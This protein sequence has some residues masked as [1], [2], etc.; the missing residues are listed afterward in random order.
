MGPSKGWRRVCLG[1]LV[2]VKH[3]FAFSGECFVEGRTPDV[4]V[5]PG[6]FALGGGFK[7][8]KPKYYGGPVP[9]PEFILSPGD[10][11]V[12][13]TDLSKTSD[14]LGYGAVVP[15]LSGVRLLHNQ[16]IGRVVVNRPDLTSCDYLHWV[17][18]SD[19]YR[20]EVL[21]SASGSTVKHTAPSRIEAYRFLLPPLE[22]QRA[23]AN[24]LGTLDE[25]IE[26]N[27][28]TNETLEAMARALFKSWFVDFDPVRAKAAGRQPSGMDADT[29][30]LFPAELV[31]SELGEIPKGWT[32]R[33]LDAIADFRNGLPLQKF[34]PA[35]GAPRLPVVKIAQMR[36]GQ[37]DGGE[38]ARA[39]IDP[40][41]IIEN[42]DVIFSWSGSLAV[43]VWSGGRAA[44]NQHLF[45]VT[46]EAYPKW[47]CL[48][49]LLLH[50]P[51]FQRIAADK[52]TTMGHIQRHHLTAAQCMVPT[53]EILR[54]ADRVFAPL[55][56]RRVALDLEARSVAR[57]RDELLPRL[58]SGE[59]PVRA[60]ERVLEAQA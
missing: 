40:K 9:P 18:R 42:G 21:A 5:T 33:S 2:S 29:A 60:A 8:D 28:R 15:I 23:I 48:Q 32:A 16:R 47:F 26:L 53:G 19:S 13:M 22:E 50:L 10:L 57:L 49:W 36:T 55:L 14:T 51:A 7:L 41:C 38:W 24:I 1:D 17:L 30:K 11:I 52:A 59:L 45:R 6:N 56:E 43:V 3:G 4:L 25:K 20:Q 34:R 31:E 37:P 27:R 12:T 46:S 54:F 58:L 44:L 39:D 35:E